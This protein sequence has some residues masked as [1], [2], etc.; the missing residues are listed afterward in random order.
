MEERVLTACRRTGFGKAAAAQ[1]RRANRLP[2]VIYDNAGRS[3]AIDVPYR[4][5]EKL[6]KT[7]TESTLITIKVDE[8][9][10]LSD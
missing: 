4:D 5:F 1:C 3:T 9:D 6:F 10:E 8:K 7:V 2:A